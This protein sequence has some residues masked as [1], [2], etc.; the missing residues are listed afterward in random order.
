MKECPLDSSFFFKIGT[1][2]VF[3]W[4]GEGLFFPI[5]SFKV[6]E[7]SGKRKHLLKFL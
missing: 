6:E 1:C 3:S 5:N 7:K 2:H 4:W